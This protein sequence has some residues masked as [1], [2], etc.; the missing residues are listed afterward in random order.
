L[1]GNHQGCPRRHRNRSVIHRL[2]YGFPDCMDL[3][4]ERALNAYTR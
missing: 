3:L 2:L 4:E 1:V